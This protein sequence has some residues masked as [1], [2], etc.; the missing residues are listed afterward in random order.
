MPKPE[1]IF[2][3]EVQ[4]SDSKIQEDH[5]HKPRLVRIEED[6]EGA[7]EIVYPTR[8]LQKALQDKS[9]EPKPRLATLTRT[10]WMR[11]A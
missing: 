5:K 9:L 11:M 10:D 8:L 1:S 4:S 7:R 6:E 3:L 2:D